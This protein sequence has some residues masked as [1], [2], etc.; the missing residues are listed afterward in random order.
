LSHPRKT[1]YSEY[2]NKKTKNKKQTNKQKKQTKQKTNNAY[3]QVKQIK[4]RTV[5]KTNRKSMEDLVSGLPEQ[6]FSPIL[7]VAPSCTIE[8]IR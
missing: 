3:I 8:I 4:R 1:R 5:R 6:S 7:F 2:K